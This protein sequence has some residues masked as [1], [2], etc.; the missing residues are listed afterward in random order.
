MLSAS[1]QVLRLAQDDRDNGTVN[2]QLRTE[3]SSRSLLFFPRAPNPPQ[4]L[5]SRRSVSSPADSDLPAA[6]RLPPFLVRHRA[7]AD[8]P[9]AGT[10]RRGV[11]SRGLGPPAAGHAVAG[12]S[13][14]LR[15]RHRVVWRNLLLDLRHH[16]PI[17]RPERAHG[18]PG[19]LSF[20]LLSRPVSR[21]LRTGCEFARPSSRPSPSLG[22]GSIPVG[23]HRTGANPH[24]RIPLGPAR[25]F[26]DR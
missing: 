23:R 12:I 15:L 9:A 18:A 5:A 8:C 24:Q 16:A 2:G 19:P 26:P 21:S 1:S 10:P 3:N 7:L 20:L 13:A 11:G 17:R 25:Y 22:A 14:G 4:R 6:G